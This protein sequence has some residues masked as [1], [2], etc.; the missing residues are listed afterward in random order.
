M[1]KGV[2]NTEST[3]E[4]ILFKEAMGYNIVLAC[5]EK[6]ATKVADSLISKLMKD[7]RQVAT[8]YYKQGYN[9][10]AISEDLSISTDEV[11]RI[12][13]AVKT[14]ITHSSYNGEMEKYIAVAKPNSTN[15]MEK[16]KE[17]VGIKD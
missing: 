12:L 6:T 4:G 2:T 5:D 8:L 11:R 15:A 10:E 16:L 3:S 13:K 1:N 7:E 14:K 17:I 9:L